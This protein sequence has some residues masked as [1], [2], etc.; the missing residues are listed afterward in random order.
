MHTSSCNSPS[1]SLPVMLLARRRSLLTHAGDAEEDSSFFFFLPSYLS[2][3]LIY[4]RLDLCGWTAGAAE[5]F[6]RWLDNFESSLYTSEN[7]DWKLDISV[8]LKKKKRSVTLT[9]LFFLQVGSFKCVELHYK[10][11]VLF[12]SPLMTLPSPLS[13]LTKQCT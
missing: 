12:C 7:G 6:L 8:E 2:W 9:E 13:W 5:R 3:L 10:L 4:V 11:L 1:S